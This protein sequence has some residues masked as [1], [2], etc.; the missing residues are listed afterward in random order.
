[1]IIGLVAPDPDESIVELLESLLERAKRGEITAI[2][3]VTMNPGE[4]FAEFFSRNAVTEKALRFI[5][6]LRVLQMRFERQIPLDPPE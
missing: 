2:A 4:E 3:G 5:S 1:M 6:F